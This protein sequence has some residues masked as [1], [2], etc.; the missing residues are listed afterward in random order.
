MMPTGG[1]V[2]L[3]MFSHPQKFQY[4]HTEATVPMMPEIRTMGFFFWPKM[5]ARP[6]P[7]EYRALSL[8]V[9]MFRPS[10]RMAR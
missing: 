5:L 8:V 10:T 7:A 9:Q 6:R 1:R 4:S 2:Q 3:R